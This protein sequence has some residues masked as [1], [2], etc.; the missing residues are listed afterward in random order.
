MNDVQANGDIDN[1][2]RPNIISK[3]KDI[4]HRCCIRRN[5]AKLTKKYD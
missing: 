5:C 3:W 1:I 2:N 4:S